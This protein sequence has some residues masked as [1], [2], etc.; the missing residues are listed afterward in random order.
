VAHLIPGAREVD[1]EAEAARLAA[2]RIRSPD[3]WPLLCES[4]HMIRLGDATPMIRIQVTMSETPGAIPADLSDRI[5]A[6]I[7]ERL[8]ATTD[9]EP[10][11]GP[12]Y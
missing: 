11:T 5:A 9:S 4:V 2:E 10:M 3:G 1:P 6:L 8:A 12:R 7:R